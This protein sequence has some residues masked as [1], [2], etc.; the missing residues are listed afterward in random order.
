MIRITVIFVV[1]FTKKKK[2]SK[3]QGSQYS[4]HILLVS[5]LLFVC[6]SYLFCE[7]FKDCVMETR[8]VMN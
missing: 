5:I 6:D 1:T 2:K 3:K 4:K 7:S 8:T